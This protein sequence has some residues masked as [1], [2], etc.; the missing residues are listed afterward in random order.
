MD[1]N[2]NLT[3][4]IPEVQSLHQCMDWR[5][6]DKISSFPDPVIPGSGG[7][8]AFPGPGYPSFAS[9]RSL[10]GDGQAKNDAG[11]SIEHEFDREKGLTLTNSLVKGRHEQ[12]PIMIDQR[13]VRGQ[14]PTTSQRFT[15]H[16]T[17]REPHPDRNMISQLQSSRCH[18]R[19]TESAPPGRR[20]D[21]DSY[22]VA[23]MMFGPMTELKDVTEE[24]FVFHMEN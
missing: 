2:N 13:Q 18:L 3:S 20:Y 10:I 16:A 6:E 12:D 1:L 24:D 22:A 8:T 11:F 5:T 21:T 17:G 14:P 15:S 7:Y 19:R 9:S 4:Q 23:Q